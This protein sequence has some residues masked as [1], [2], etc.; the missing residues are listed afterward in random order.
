MTVKIGY[1][2]LWP[3]TMAVRNNEA[4]KEPHTE[5]I[6]TLPYRGGCHKSG[7][8]TECVP[9]S[10]LHQIASV[11]QACIYYY[12]SRRK[13]TV[14]SSLFLSL[15]FRF[16]SSS[17]FF[18]LFKYSAPP[19]QNMSWGGAHDFLRWVYPL[20]GRACVPISNNTDRTI[21]T[22]SFHLRGISFCL[23]I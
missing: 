13:F 10:W 20:M 8:E 16:L 19:E 6:L 9:S 2:S 17:F 4:K 5:S 12:H 3:L 7:H 11:A 22:G 18:F 15:L 14:P 21:R 23:S 1:P